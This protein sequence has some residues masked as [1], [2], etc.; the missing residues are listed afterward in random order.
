MLTDHKLEEFL[1]ISEGGNRSPAYDDFQ[2]W[3]ELQPGDE[4]K[5]TL[6]LGPG[7][8]RHADGSPIQIGDTMSDQEAYERL[9]AYIR[10]EIEPVLE[11]LIHVPIAVSMANA[12]GS[13]VYN[14][15]A[16]E[17]YG[18]KLWGRI[19]AG[20]PAINIINEWID[21]TFL[22]KGVP[23]LGLWRRRFKELALAFGVDW[24]AGENVDWEHKPDQFLE[25]LGWDG[26]MPKPE[27]I[28]DEDLFKELEIPTRG[29]DEMTREKGADPTP[30]T[31]IT[32]DDAQFLSAEAAGY[33]GSYADFMSHRTVV[34]TRNA[35][36]APKIDVKKPPKPMEDSKTHRGLAKKTSGKEG[37]DVGAI[38]AGAGSVAGAMNSLTKNTAQTV[39]NTQPLVAGFTLNHIII[40]AMVLGF[41]L[42][43]YGAWRMYRG[44]MIAREGR[45]DGTQLK[46]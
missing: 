17:V 44:E 30:E 33:E 31:P 35:I 23:M 16:T 42:L 3:K 21:G 19:N 13:L 40:M 39:E 34:T 27:P 41:S 8:T 22:S 5:G 4:I 45:Q 20:E 12:L 10:D 1:F 43:V 18:W 38:L 29:A 37:R 28:V 6:T 15:G 14:F 7:F 24:R 46:V 2:P 26:T 32:M 9:R 36:E 25:M 11:D